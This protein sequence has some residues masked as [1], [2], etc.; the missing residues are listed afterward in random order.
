MRSHDGTHI[1]GKQ[2][3]R[4]LMPLFTRIS[5]PTTVSVSMKLIEGFAKTTRGLR[6]EIGD[7]REK[8]KIAEAAMKAMK[9]NN[10]AEREEA[11]LELQ[12]AYDL[13]ARTTT[14]FRIETLC[15][16]DTA[17]RRFTFVHSKLMKRIKKRVP[18]GQHVSAWLHDHVQLAAS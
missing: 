12:A 18:T 5:S 9:E 3:R 16:N 13:A 1:T 8:A 2:K 14:C 4:S 6:E 15:N 11:E 10:E 17:I 7:L